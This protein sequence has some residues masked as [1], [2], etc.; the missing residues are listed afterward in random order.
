MGFP[1]HGATAGGLPTQGAYTSKQHWGG[2]R[3]PAIT[4]EN[5]GAEPITLP[6]EAIAQWPLTGIVKRMCGEFV[7]RA[8]H[9]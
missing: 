7:F 6:P 9:Q 5:I 1:L 3:V 4:E 2:G 8:A